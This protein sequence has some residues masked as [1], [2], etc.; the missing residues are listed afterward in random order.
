M[1]QEVVCWI[2]S[3]L[4]NLPFLVLIFILII[5][6][7]FF[8]LRYCNIKSISSSSF[9]SLYFC[10]KHQGDLIIFSVLHE[11]TLNSFHSELK[12]THQSQQRIITRITV[13]LLCFLLFSCIQSSLWII[14]FNFTTFFNNE[15]IITRE[16]LPQYS[17]IRF[18]DNPRT[19]IFCHLDYHCKWLN[20]F[21]IRYFLFIVTDSTAFNT[22][23][24]YPYSEQFN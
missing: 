20:N 3:T 6:I 15:L 7:K 24:S 1:L 4:F 8:N 17:C 14:N 22:S 12:V 5:S 19:A 21:W 13:F 10:V 23:I 16:G 9:L 2:F 11:S 18:K